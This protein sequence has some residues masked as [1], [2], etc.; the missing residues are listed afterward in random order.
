MGQMMVHVGRRGPCPVTPSAVAP[1]ACKLLPARQSGTAVV[2]LDSDPGLPAQQMPPFGCPPELLLR[3]GAP[4]RRAARC[5]ADPAY[6]T[7]ANP[8]RYCSTERRG[9]RRG[10][11]RR[12]GDREGETGIETESARGCGRLSLSQPTARVMKTLK[13]WGKRGGGLLGQP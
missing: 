3:P 2:P 12:H 4:A 7:D 5:A 8:S 13:R 9:S 11:R 10:P 6:E 1:G